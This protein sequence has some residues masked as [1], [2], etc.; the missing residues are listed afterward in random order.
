MIASSRL[1][2]LI[3]IMIMMSGVWAVQPFSCSYA[4]DSYSCH[5]TPRIACLTVLHMPGS[6]LRI[7]ATG[8]RSCC[9]LSQQLAISQDAEQ[10]QR[11]CGCRKD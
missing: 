5:D 6:P 4:G 9:C 2:D 10:P 8:P 7:L 11:R 3:I 1:D